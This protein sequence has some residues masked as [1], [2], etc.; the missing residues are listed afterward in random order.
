[1]REVQAEYL[2]RSNSPLSSAASLLSIH[3]KPATTRLIETIN[4]FLTNIPKIQEN[5]LL[6]EI[7]K[8]QEIYISL[9]NNLIDTERRRTNF[10]LPMQR[11]RTILASA[12]ELERERARY[13]AASLEYDNQLQQLREDAALVEQIINQTYTEK[14]VGT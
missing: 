13:A 7:I 1:M 12:K 4:T 5:T 2:K 14:E 6:P 10:E 8:L 3:K 11:Q 9:Q